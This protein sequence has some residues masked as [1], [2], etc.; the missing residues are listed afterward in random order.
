MSPGSVG[1]AQSHQICYKDM[2]ERRIDRSVILEDDVILLPGFVEVLRCLDREMSLD[3]LVLLFCQ[4]VKTVA[5]TPLS[6][7]RSVRANRAYGV[8]YAN[9]RHLH[10]AVAYAIGR[11]VAQSLLTAN[12]P[13]RFP[14]DAWSMYYKKGGYRYL[15]VVH[16][17]PIMHDYASDFGTRTPQHS[18]TRAAL[19]TV[20]RMLP[21]RPIVNMLEYMKINRKFKLVPDPSPYAPSTEMAERTHV[22]DGDPHVQTRFEECP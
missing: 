5:H 4:S 20:Y 18:R 16:P 12:S 8:Y 11:N 1:C 22:L 19:G 7:S 13:I 17:S 9:R 14:A 2:L 10:G 21:I 15:R 3:D 6:T